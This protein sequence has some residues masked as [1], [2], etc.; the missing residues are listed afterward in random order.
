M[1]IGECF[2]N[3]VDGFLEITGIGGHQA[4]QVNGRSNERRRYVST[5]QE[6]VQS[7]DK[8]INKLQD[9]ETGGEYTVR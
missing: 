4:I 5:S 2:L 6:G 3:A 9:K 8:I 1:L 7:G